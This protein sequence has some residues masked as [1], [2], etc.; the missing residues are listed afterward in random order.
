[1]ILG[2]EKEG[3]NLPNP[4]NI[5]LNRGRTIYLGSF[6]DLAS[7]LRLIWEMLDTFPVFLNVRTFSLVNL[8]SASPRFD[9]LPLHRSISIAGAG[10]KG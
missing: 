4:L 9:R 5:L 8:G 2:G 1:M 6:Y 3:G 10:S 7:S